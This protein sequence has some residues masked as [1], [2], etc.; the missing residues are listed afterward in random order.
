MVIY[1]KDSEFPTLEDQFDIPP[2][3]YKYDYGDGLNLSPGTDLHDKIV[4]R[5]MEFAYQSNSVIR[6]RYDLWDKLDQNLTAYVPMT[7]LEN[8]RKSADRREPVRIVIP[9]TAAI[10]ET[11]LTY[12]VS[13]FVQDKIFRYRGVGGEKDLIGA[14]LLEHDIAQQCRINKVGLALK[15]I[16]RDALVYGFGTGVVSWTSRMEFRKSARTGLLGFFGNNERTKQVVFEGNEL[17][18]IDPRY[19]LPDPNVPIHEP[20]KGEFVGWIYQ[21]NYLNLL[22]NDQENGGDLINVQYLRNMLSKRSALV[23]D[24]SRRNSHRDDRLA[25]PSAYDTKVVDIIPMYVNLIPNDWG[26]GP[27]NFPEKWLFE[28]ANDSILI[29]AEPQNLDHDRFPVIV[30]A[31]ESDGYSVTPISRMEIIYPMQESLDWFI[32]SHVTN[33]LKGVND[34][35]LVNPNAVNMNDMKKRDGG[36]FIRL[37]PNAFGMSLDQVVKQFPVSDV[38]RNHVN[39]ASMF[40]D[41]MQRVSAATDPLQGII[42]HR[43]DRVSASEFR[44]TSSNNFGRLNMVGLTLALQMMQDAAYLF[45]SHTVQLSSISRSVRIG[46][47]IPQELSSIYTPGTI[48]NI[49]PEDLDI[50]Y[51]VVIENLGMPGGEFAEQWVQLAQMVFTDP[52]LRTIFDVPKIFKHIAKLMGAQNVDNFIRQGAGMQATVMPDQAVQEAVSAGNMVPLGG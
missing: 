10:L 8:Q 7:D 33:V 14:F 28:V 38:T 3:S 17:I 25:N 22:E 23:L 6:E 50:N 27:S 20:Q 43:G 11:V 21:S 49:S 16:L 5:V 34:Q 45:A 37:L 47:D 39:D 48:A 35:W 13:L 42:Q 30:G 44:G 2:V 18:N 32:N 46:G 51:D 41:F 40:L 19:Y 26:L 12:L 15:Y 29:R 1:I 24:D 4:D 36:R 31:P 52:E 9:Q